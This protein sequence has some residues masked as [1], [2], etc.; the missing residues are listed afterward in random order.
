MRLFTKKVFEGVVQSSTGGTVPVYS[1][2]EYE[3][4]LG[5]CETLA[6]E[7]V[8]TDIVGSP[9]RVQ[10]D[11]Q[12]S[13]TGNTWTNRMTNVASGTG[14]P[15]AGNVNTYLGA[16]TNTTRGGSLVRLA[17][18]VTAPSGTVNIQVIACG[19]AEQS[20]V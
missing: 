12:W 5:A 13:N 4:M 14:T 6:L 17:I 10:V 16:E 18:Y 3:S 1:L 7:V 11:T 15:I 8:V 19:R 20:W 2:P 9:T